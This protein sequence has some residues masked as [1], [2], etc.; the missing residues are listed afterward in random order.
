MSEVHARTDDVVTTEP[1]LLKRRERD[2]EG[3]DRLLVR[4]ASGD[5]A[6]HYRGAAGDQ[7]QAVR[8]LHR[9]GV[10]EGLL[11][12]RTGRDTPY[13]AHWATASKASSRVNAFAYRAFPTMEPST[14]RGTSSAMA[15][16]SSRDDTPPDAT[17]GRSVAAQTFFSSSRLG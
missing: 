17:T 1:Q 4:A 9:T 8:Q 5:L 14:P 12:G 2:V 11:P 3:V 7:H 16:R 6:V 10:A 15:R 13:V